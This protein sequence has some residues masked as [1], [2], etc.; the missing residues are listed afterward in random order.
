MNNNY[1]IVFYPRRLMEAFGLLP[2]LPDKPIEP[3]KPKEPH[4]PTEEKETVSGFIIYLIVISIPT[5]ILV[6]NGSDSI[7]VSII[8]IFAI[9]G[10]LRF[11]Y[12]YNIKPKSEYSDKISNYNIDYLKYKQDLIEFDKN[13]I[14]YTLKLEKYEIEVKHI[15]SN[16]NVLSYRN[17]AITDL[18]EYNYAKFIEL[19]ILN[20]PGRKL[21]ASIFF[22]RKFLT[23]AFTENHVKY[24]VTLEK[25]YLNFLVYEAT[26]GLLINIEVDAPY[27]GCS[28]KP[29]NFVES[30]L[31]KYPNKYEYKV[32]DSNIILIRFAEVQI[33]NY[34]NECINHIKSIIKNAKAGN[35]SFNINSELSNVDFWYKEEA[36][37]M[38][39]K[40]FRHTYIPD[41]LHKNIDVEGDLYKENELLHESISLKILKKKSNLNYIPFHTKDKWTLFDTK[42]EK[43]ISELFDDAYFFDNTL[44]SSTSCIIKLNEEYAIVHNSLDLIDIKWFKKIRMLE[45]FKECCFAFNGFY[46]GIVSHKNEILLPFEHLGFLEFNYKNTFAGYKKNGK[47]G[48]IDLANFNICIPF[49]YDKLYRNNRDDE[50]I[51]RL[52]KNDEI[53]I[54]DMLEK[55]II[56][57]KEAEDISHYSEN[58]LSIKYNQKWMLLKNSESQYS[59]IN[60]RMYDTTTKYENGNSL[61]SINEKWFLVNE[62]GVETPI[63]YSHLTT[64]SKNELYKK[65]DIVYFRTFDNN[66]D[67]IS[68]HIYYL[69]KYI[70]TLKQRSSGTNSGI[71]YSIVPIE[72]KYIDI[73]CYFRKYDSSGLLRNCTIYGN[74]LTIDEYADYMKIKNNRVKTFYSSIYNDSDNFNYIDISWRIINSDKEEKLYYKDT[75]MYSGK[76]LKII[77]L[78]YGLALL[79]EDVSIDADGLYKT[80][81]GYFDVFGNIYWN[82]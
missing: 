19:E 62:K 7:I 6:A 45:H 18:I 82:N 10:L 2:P 40:K 28:G 46:W 75:I 17:N 52:S 51:I 23:D 33:F 48:L 12:Y 13:I 21:N 25:C 22:F 63:D 24:G 47:F 67:Y 38:A 16:E 81:V 5:Y 39:Y 68:F 77:E 27:I 72:N 57:I 8:M 9:L 73:K 78:D 14:D 43:L 79:L 64:E 55:K 3:K 53:G 36:H 69:D 34:P 76:D 49:E 41:F 80:E 31:E 70:S 54:F 60:Q 32:L 44:E 71:S 1:P 58:I 37:E 30:S 35:F 4:K 20:I 66:S 50:N 42:N 15:L 11:Y 61:C 29:I 56:K 65:G 59:Y 74:E 26:T